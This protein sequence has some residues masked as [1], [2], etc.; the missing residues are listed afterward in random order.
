LSRPVPFITA[1]VFTDRVFGGNPLAVFPDAAGIDPAAMQLVARELNLSETVFVLPPDDPRHTAR[2]RIFT[3]AME[4][5]FAGHPTV[6]TAIILAQTGRL[7]PD[8]EEIVL[9][10]EV[11]PVPVRLERHPDGPMTAAL[12]APRLP[13]AVAQAAGAGDL[14]RVLGLD[15]SAIEEAGAAPGCYG[16]GVPFTIVPLRDSAALGAITFN[17]AAWNEVLRS[18]GAPHVYAVTMDDWAGGNEIRA[19]MFAPAM[20]IDEDPATGAAATALAGFLADLLPPWTGT[21]RWVVRQGEEMGRPSLI[22]LEADAD[23]GTL[24]AVRVA[25]QAIIVSRGEF[26]LP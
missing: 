5:P 17:R 12:S 21:R 13:A 4:L 14:S 7:G 26:F 3:P 8:T 19:R 6:G 24:G 18:T 2:I 25:G 15:R 9:E 20:E 16:A 22:L 23:A 11:G 1:D 10:E